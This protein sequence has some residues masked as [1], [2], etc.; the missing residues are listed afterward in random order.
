M[1]FA[2]ARGDSKPRRGP[3]VIEPHGKRFPFEGPEAIDASL[4]ETFD[5]E[6]P[7]REVALDVSTDEFTCVCPF[8]GLPD[9]GTIRIDYIPDKKCIELRSLKY[10][11]TTYRNVGIYHEH[12]VNRILED[13]VA[14]CRPLRM[15]VIADYKVR[16]GIHTVASVEY[17]KPD[18][19]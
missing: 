8:S 3:P 9:F 18:E 7:G 13:L 12:A 10:Y 11:L 2:A 17:T 4:L 1:R 19:S 14:C 5:Y 15:K 6:Y 16:G